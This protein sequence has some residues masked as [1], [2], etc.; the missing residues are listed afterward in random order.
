MSANGPSSA[1]A[2]NRFVP[3]SPALTELPTAH[4]PLKE[5]ETLDEFNKMI[6][7]E[8]YIAVDPFLMR[9]RGWCVD[10]CETYNANGLDEKDRLALFSDWVSLT[11]KH[12]KNHTEGVFV[13]KPFTCEYV[14]LQHQVW[15]RDLSWTGMYID[16]RGADL[17]WLP[18]DARGQRSDLHTHPSP[19]AGS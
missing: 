3:D 18:L 12:P 4:P 10:K 19:F 13:M 7:G 11:V 2:G 8:P 6:S 9:V 5:G 15:E 17:H 1:P 16:R 14:R